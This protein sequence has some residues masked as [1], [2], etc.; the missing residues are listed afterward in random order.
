MASI[1]D[2]KKRIGT[3]KNTQQTT[4]AMKMVSAAKLRR[5]QDAIL[6]QRPYAQRTNEL[7][8]VASSL[9]EG[10][11]ESPLL[12]RELSEGAKPKLA[13]VIVTSDRGLC[14]GFNANVI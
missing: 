9:V 2:L 1:K 3:V 4:R 14:G 5:A 6:A 10:K 7:I 13:L 12:G 8:R 11:F